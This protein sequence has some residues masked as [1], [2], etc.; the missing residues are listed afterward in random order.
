MMKMGWGGGY[1]FGGTA[2]VGGCEGELGGVCCCRLVSPEVVGLC[3]SEGEGCAGGQSAGEE[4]CRS[5][6]GHCDQV[7]SSRG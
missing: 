1:Y 4:G 5:E 3:P 7:A 2:V 6:D